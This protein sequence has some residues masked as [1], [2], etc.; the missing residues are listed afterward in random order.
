[1]RR[2]YCLPDFGSLNPS[3]ILA[4]VSVKNRSIIGLTWRST[5]R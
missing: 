5:D 1:L 2:G 4:F 3:I